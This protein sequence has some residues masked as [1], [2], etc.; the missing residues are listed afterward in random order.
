MHINKL[1]TALCA[2][3]VAAHKLL[4]GCCRFVFLFYVFL[5]TKLYGQLRTDTRT[6]HCNDTRTEEEENNKT[7][8][9]NSQMC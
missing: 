7:K 8:I 9:T 5:V 1:Y 4:S 2:T 6:P 3:I